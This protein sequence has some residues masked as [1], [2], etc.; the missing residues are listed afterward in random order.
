MGLTASALFM[1]VPSII[2]FAPG[3][4]IVFPLF[5]VT[6]ICFLYMG[7]KRQRYVY[8]FISGIVVCLGLFFSLNQLATLLLMGLIYLFYSLRKIR[9]S[10]G[11][12]EE[13][14]KALP[15]F[16]GF[17]VL[18]LISGILTMFL[19]YRVLL[20]INLFQILYICRLNNIVRFFSNSNRTY[21]KWIIL[22]MLDFS[23]FIGVAISIPLACKY[24]SDIR[25]FLKK[26]DFTL[27][28]P[29]CLSFIL[30]LAILNFSG[31]N[32]GETA[33]LWIFLMP[34]AVLIASTKLAELDFLKGN[35]IPVILFYQFVQ[36]IMFR[37]C[38]CVHTL[39]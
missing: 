33:R 32:L 36:T 8:L 18:S 20:G 7:L 38:I 14:L 34:I 3:Y 26:K 35:A 28:D 30:L 15:N 10:P 39:L 23:L 12:K 22:N 24:F 17:G 27:L 13:N 9:M 5:T 21:Y 19:I 31:Q 25:D 16:A 6:S 37:L 29:L 2:L 11:K 4:D 1:L